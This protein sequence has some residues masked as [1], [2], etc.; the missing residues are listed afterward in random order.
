MVF[1]VWFADGSCTEVRFENW[2]GLGAWAMGQ[3]P[4]V[5]KVE[6]KQ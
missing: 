6:V 2:L 5:V 1:K 4:K 3:N